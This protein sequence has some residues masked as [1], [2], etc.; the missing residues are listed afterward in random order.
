MLK[1]SVVYMKKSLDKVT[2]KPTHDICN[3]NVRF[4]LYDYVHV[5]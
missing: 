5:G 3:T 1:K 4:N 2:P